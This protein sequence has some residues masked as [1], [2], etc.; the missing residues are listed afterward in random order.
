[1]RKYQSSREPFVFARSELAFARPRL[2]LP[3]L[4]AG[5]VG[6]GAVVLVLVIAGFVAERPLPPAAVP[7]W[8]TVALSFALA[9]T[10]PARLPLELS[11][12]QRRHGLFRGIRRLSAQ[13]PAPGHLL[14]LSRMA[15]PPRCSRPANRCG[16]P[17]WC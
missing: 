11:A 14:A 16:V 3:F 15:W 12:N 7:G 4:S 5:K 2:Y 1:M 9:V 17:T 13:W 8:L 6:A 10:I